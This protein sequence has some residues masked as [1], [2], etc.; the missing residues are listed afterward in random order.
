MVNQDVNAR[1]FRDMLTM[2][3]SHCGLLGQFKHAYQ[4]EEAVRNNDLSKKNN[5]VH[6][7]SVALFLFI[8]LAFKDQIRSCINV[9]Q[10]K[11]QM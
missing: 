10:L 3:I 2:V 11:T 9:K 5:R 4:N 8:C 1:D 6:K 7:K